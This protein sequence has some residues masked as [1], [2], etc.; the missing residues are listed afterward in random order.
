MKAEY[1]WEEG[2][3]IAG[4]NKGDDINLVEVSSPAFEGATLY[5]L[6]EAVDFGPCAFATAAP[7]KQQGLMS[8]LTRLAARCAVLSNF[9]RGCGVKPAP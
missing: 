7:E 5:L 1:F 8:V 2:A 6:L 4:Y 9:P 3:S